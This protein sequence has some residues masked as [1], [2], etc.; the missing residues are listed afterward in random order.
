MKLY[1]PM[2]CSQKALASHHSQ[3]FAST[4]GGLSLLC[5]SATADHYHDAGSRWG[6]GWDSSPQEASGEKLPSEFPFLLDIFKTNQ[7]KVTV[8]SKVKLVKH[9]FLLRPNG[10]GPSVK[11]FELLPRRSALN[12]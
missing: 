12:L 7:N 2:R 4:A 1:I 11:Y 3:S 6:P 8:E 5:K 9:F 10:A